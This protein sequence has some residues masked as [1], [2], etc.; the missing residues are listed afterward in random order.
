M[1]RAKGRQLSERQRK[2]AHAYAETP[3]A[4]AAA[5]A[6]GYSPAT[7]RDT[8]PRLLKNPEVKR[9]IDRIFAER[10]DRVVVTKQWVIDQAVQTARAARA[11]ANHAATVGALKLA[12]QVAGVL[13]ERRETRQVQD[14][15]DLI[16]EELRAL[17]AAKHPRERDTTTH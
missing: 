13:I 17:A 3:S 1:A 15:S 7:A 11:S 8:G 4:T 9:E 6:A 5:I 14:W 12:A 10:T 16:D 2:F